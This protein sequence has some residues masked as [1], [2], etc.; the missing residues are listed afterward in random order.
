MHPSS[1]K[2]TAIASQELGLCIIHEAI[3]KGHDQV[4][5]SKSLLRVTAPCKMLLLLNSAMS[6]AQSG[7]EV[8]ANSP[9][10]PRHDYGIAWTHGLLYHI[11]CLS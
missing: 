7:G 8:N 11:F 10:I 5:G 6:P 3:R 1:L 2:S 9:R 4:C